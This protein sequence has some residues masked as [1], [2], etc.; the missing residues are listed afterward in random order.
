MRITFPCNAIP[1]L[2]FFLSVNTIC[3]SQNAII[4]GIIRHGNEILQSATITIGEQTKI[5]DV[6]GEF[7]FSVKPGV[8]TI[9]ITYTGYKKTQQEIKAA[10]DTTMNFVFEMIPIEQLGEVVMIG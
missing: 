7:S 6:N 2:G 4:K 9:I 1:S 10:A 3:F 5:T 8:Y